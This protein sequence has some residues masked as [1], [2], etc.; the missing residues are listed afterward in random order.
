MTRTAVVAFAAIALGVGIAAAFK[1]PGTT[2]PRQAAGRAIRRPT[3]PRSQTTVRQ[4]VSQLSPSQLAGQRVIYA[5]AGL[6]PPAAL[7]ER[8]RR[9][10]AGGVIL[11]GPNIGTH[12]Q[13]ST[14]I[15]TLQQA[16]TESVVHMPLLVMTDQEGGQVRRLPGGPLFS[17][18][19]I[20]AQENAEI[21]AGAAGAEAAIELR[22]W[23]FNVNLAP[24]LDVA[25]SSSG[26]IGH[27]ERSYGNDPRRV[28]ELGSAFISAQQASG[29]AATAKHFPGLGSADAEQNT[30]LEQATL[31]T[32]LATLRAID[33]APYAR[34]IAAGVR[35]VMTSWATY[36]ALDPSQPAG[37]SPIVIQGELRRR[38]GFR[39]VTITDGIGAGALA[40]YGS[41]AHRG[42]LAAEAGADLVLSTARTLTENTPIEGIAVLH[43]IRHGLRAALQRATSEEAA[44]RIL[45]LRQQLTRN[46]SPGYDAR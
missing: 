23:G 31:A 22:S 2:R 26:F 11:F 21:L 4:D 43:A 24:V 35:L 6:T 9:A 20:G 30:D 38:I 45:S 14:E 5:Y 37:L 42:Q 7:L 46:P 32:P 36:P 18:K 25:R 3:D 34:A 39:G 28:G 27:Y 29:I 33:E 13:T 8:V 12:A 15:R 17:E 1:S 16:A 41:D 10:E 40:S 44:T 19:Q